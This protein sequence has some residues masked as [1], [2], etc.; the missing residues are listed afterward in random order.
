MFST[1]KNLIIG[2]NRDDLSNYLFLLV[3]KFK[4]NYFFTKIFYWKLKLGRI[5]I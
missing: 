3:R 5:L 2:M 1:F 4:A